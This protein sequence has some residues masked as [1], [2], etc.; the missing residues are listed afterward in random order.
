MRSST[1]FLLVDVRESIEE[2]ERLHVMDAVYCARTAFLTQDKAPMDLHMAKRNRDAWLIIYDE[3]GPMAQGSSPDAC[4][5]ADKLVKIGVQNVAVLHGGLRAVLAVEPFALEGSAASDIA[6][7]A[8]AKMAAPLS[9]AQARAQGR[10]DRVKAAGLNPVKAGGSNR[11]AGRSGSD[12]G[13]LSSYG[14]SVGPSGGP[15]SPGKMSTGVSSMRSTASSKAPG[16]AAGSVYAMDAVKKPTFG[17]AARF[18]LA[19]VEE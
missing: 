19:R 15:S 16:G 4:A 11:S 2:F 10:L 14:A 5:V 8:A 6:E 7:E 1:P 9:A 12:A 13:S 18:N 3:G 17:T